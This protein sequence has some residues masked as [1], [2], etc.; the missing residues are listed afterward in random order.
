MATEIATTHV[1]K[2]RRFTV[3]EYE[4]MIEAGILDENDRVELIDGEILEKV[5]ITAPH[6]ASVTEIGSWFILGL[7]GR[8]IVSVHN[9]ICIPPCSEPEPDVVLLR[10]R[11][12]RYRENLPGPE[13]VL[14]IVEVSDSTLPYDREAKLPLYAAAGIPEVW[15]VDLARRRVLVH[16][17]PDG[18]IYREA[19][20][21]DSGSL[22]PLAFPALA[23]G[24]A[25]IF[26]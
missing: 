10:P 13:S 14:L 2:R 11:P 21:V 23:I 22:S 6:A 20:V 18:D 16:R 17:Q 9:P 19:V 12:D 24:M 7:T 5:R 3:D 4:G 8:A 25:E 26:G 1:R 15:I